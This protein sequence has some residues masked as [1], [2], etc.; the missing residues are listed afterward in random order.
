M[1]TIRGAG[2]V[3]AGLMALAGAAFAQGAVIEATTAHG[4]RVRL[5]PDGRW[6]WV[7]GARSA[8]QRAERAAEARRDE[9]AR[10]A[11]LRRERNAQGGGVIGLGRTI[12]EGDRD[13]NRGSL[14]P[15]LR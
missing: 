9:E 13:Y 7:D 4:E 12:Y 10:A 5:L 6:E 1:A 15:K 14:N 2:A 11:Q 8:V 3:A